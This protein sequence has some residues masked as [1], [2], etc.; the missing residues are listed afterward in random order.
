[1]EDLKARLC[2]LAEGDVAL[3]L[4]DFVVRRPGRPIEKYGLR[5]YDEV[6]LAPMCIFE[7]RVIEFDRKRIGMHPTPPDVTEEILES[8]SDHF[9]QAMIISTQHLLPSPSSATE[10]PL[11]G[12]VS[13][14]GQNGSTTSGDVGPK[15][16]QQEI[17][18]NSINGSTPP[19]K[20]ST[21]G[22]AEGTSDTPMDVVDVESDNKPSTPS[23]PTVPSQQTQ[24]QPIAT[25]TSHSDGHSIDICFEA[26]KLP[27]DVAIFNS[28]RA[29]GGDE[30][31]RKYLQAVLVIGGTALIPGMAHALESRLQAIATPLVQNM[32]KVQIIPPPKDV[33]PAI[34]AW[35]G[36]SVLGKMD[37]VADLWLTATDWDTL[38][39]RGL[40]ERCFYL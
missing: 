31:I 28:A 40:K 10:Q 4:Y 8:S 16:E 30:K 6:I 7:P 14:S 24:C 37:G 5:A 12:Q 26:S 9:T 11:P 17:A 23:L 13:Q 19:T 15:Q 25:Q 38:G 36:A 35:K 32:E 39:M 33:D 1:M 27:L 18:L 21:N 20:L 34:L 3:N 2:T 22:D 29:A